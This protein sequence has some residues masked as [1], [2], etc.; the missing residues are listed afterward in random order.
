MSL[1]GLQKSSVH[2]LKGL[3]VLR[4]MKVLSYNFSGSNVKEFLALKNHLMN[5]QTLLGLSSMAKAVWQTFIE[6]ALRALFLKQCSKR[7][8]SKC[9]NWPPDLIS[10]SSKI[11]QK[12]IWPPDFRAR[13]RCQEKSRYSLD[14]AN[15]VDCSLVECAGRQIIKN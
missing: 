1:F 6:S 5:R 13:K 11:C 2:A 9:R 14:E 8:H 4:K 10:S 15:C 7:R 12:K 3:K